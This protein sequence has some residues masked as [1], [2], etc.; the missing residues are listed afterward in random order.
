MA[1]RA[2]KVQKELNVCRYVATT[3]LFFIAQTDPD[4][5]V[6]WLE[7]FKRESHIEDDKMLESVAKTISDTFD[8]AKK[9]VAQEEG[10][11]F[12]DAVNQQL[13]DQVREGLE[14]P[15]DDDAVNEVMSGM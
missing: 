6:L 7:G 13:R 1:K 4:G 3:V 10:K 11:T 2:E 12:D 14:Y 5:F 15:D 9:Y 8:N